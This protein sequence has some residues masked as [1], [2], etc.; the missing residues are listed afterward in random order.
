MPTGGPESPTRGGSTSTSSVPSLPGL[1][2]HFHVARGHTR[3]LRKRRATLHKRR[4]APSVVIAEPNPFCLSSDNGLLAGVGGGRNFRRPASAGAISPHH[5]VSVERKKTFGSRWRAIRPLH[6][7]L[8]EPYPPLSPQKSS[9][10]AMTSPGVRRGA[11][12]REE[13][14][15]SKTVNRSALQAQ[16]RGSLLAELS[17][18]RDQAEIERLERKQGLVERTMRGMEALASVEQAGVNAFMKQNSLDAQRAGEALD[19]EIV[20]R[21]K[22]E[23]EETRLLASLK[24]HR[25]RKK[26]IKAELSSLIK[27]RTFYTTVAD[28]RQTKQNASA[29]ARVFK[30]RRNSSFRPAFLKRIP[31]D[32][33][34]LRMELE[35]PEQMCDI[36]ND[37][38]SD[39]TFHLQTLGRVQKQY[40]E[41]QAEVLHGRAASDA[42]VAEKRAHIAALELQ[43]GTSRDAVASTQHALDAKV[44]SLPSSLA[45]LDEMIA[46]VHHVL[47]TTASHGQGLGRPTTSTRKVKRSPLEMLARLEVKV[48]EVLELLDAKVDP[49]TRIRMHKKLKMERRKNKF[50]EE[51]EKQEK[52]KLE[53]MQRRAGETHATVRPPPPRKT[54]FVC[55]AIVTGAQRAAARAHRERQR[56]EEEE[57]RYLM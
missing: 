29:L 32:D 20:M 38:E 10:A 7:V 40:E 15:V 54:T 49:A 3:L 55:S 2:H 18:L 27:L 56:Q 45:A 11:S 57:A 6:V 22:L 23:A 26:D 47:L 39:G 52:E 25:A 13:R 28:T 8:G 19:H 33:R 44:R 21:R 46:K 48:E 35:H 37:L 41:D 1:H 42:V 17:L 50:R 5:A 51:K 36:F 24:T 34:P 14:V 12:P 43:L 4:A 9:R 53:R 30:Q 16:A 31:Q